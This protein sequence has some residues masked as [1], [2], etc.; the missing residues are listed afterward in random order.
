MNI[1]PLAT[2]LLVWALGARSDVNAV[3]WQALPPNT[4]VPIKPVLVQ[5]DGSDDRG[6][7]V[8]AGWN[9]LVFD[10]DGKRVLFY[11]RWVD[12]KH[13]GDTIYGNCLYSF[14]PDSAKLI[15]IKIAN[16]VKEPKPGGGYAT[17]PLPENAQEPTPCD[18]HVYHAFEWVPDLK[19]I[20][21]CNGANQTAVRDEKVVGHKE[22]NDTWRFG[23]EQ[24]VWKKVDSQQHPANHLE[25]GMGY[26]PDTKAIVYAGHGKIWIL[27]LASGQW[28][29]AKN[30]LPRAHMGMSVFYDGPRKRMLLVGGGAYGAWTTKAGGF[31][32]LYAFDPRTETVSALADCPTA[33]CRGALAHDTQRDLF[34]TAAV[35]P[36]KEGVEQPS[37]VFCYDPKRNEWKEIKSANAI[38]AT[39]WMPLCYDAVHDCFIGM[40]SGKTFHAF[41]P[42]LEK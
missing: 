25:D 27:D 16:W 35:M 31:N 29:P 12:K 28:R 37:G 13:G 33:L 20:F 40:G 10:A 18:R 42:A 30:N 38:P 21:I 34:V 26:C 11:D 7:W 17:K 41:R 32:G 36:K 4:W 19:E 22:V 24:K 3:D 2:L 5:S 23:L 14:E 6:T 1:R 8:Q 39:G 9:K 15:P